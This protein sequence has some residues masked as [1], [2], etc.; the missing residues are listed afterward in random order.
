L[1]ESSTVVAGG[2]RAEQQQQQEKS[3]G[4]EGGVGGEGDDMAEERQQ[5]VRTCRKALMLLSYVCQSHPTDCEAVA[6]FG[7][8]GPL[9]QLLRD[10]DDG[11]REGALQ[12]LV[13]VAS[14]PAGWMHVE[15]QQ[16]ELQQQL[17]VL[18]QQQSTRDQE[19]KEAYKEEQQLVEQLLGML[20]AGVGP[21]GVKAGTSD[22]IE[23]DPY[24]DGEKGSKTVE[25]GSSQQQQQQQ[26]AVGSGVG[27]GA[28]MLVPKQEM[29]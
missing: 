7:A 14:H 26:E 18:E 12:L 11:L 22:H 5:H 2:E 28:I 27:G 10:A 25:L 17:K 20:V 23:V 9:Q 6:G 1:D 8:V 21:T 24:L 3:A 16:G 19:G 29:R 15:E 4:G 13:E